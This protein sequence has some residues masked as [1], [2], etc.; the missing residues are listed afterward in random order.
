MREFRSTN[1]RRR[2]QLLY[3]FTITLLYITIPPITAATPPWQYIISTDRT[4]TLSQSPGRRGEQLSAYGRHPLPRRHYHTRIADT[5]VRGVH[6]R[7]KEKPLT[8]IRAHTFVLYESLT[9]RFS[10]GRVIPGFRWYVTHTTSS[11]CSPTNR[12]APGKCS[13]IFWAR[14]T[15]KRYFMFRANRGPFSMTDVC[16]ERYS[17]ESHGLR[18]QWR[19]TARQPSWQT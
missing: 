1:V 18:C 14:D 8:R 4:Q 6:V 15:T 7:A 5:S 10:P 11:S 13:Q 19:T 9:Y 17:Y 16:S 12:S 2:L 3:G